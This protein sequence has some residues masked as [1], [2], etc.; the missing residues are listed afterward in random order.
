[1]FS[2]RIKM[3]ITGFFLLLTAFLSVMGYLFEILEKLISTDNTAI[4]TIIK[5]CTT[6]KDTF[7]THPFAFTLF[8]IGLAV[9][10]DLYYAFKYSNSQNDLSVRVGRYIKNLLA[11]LNI[12]CCIDLL[13]TEGLSQKFTWVQ[14]NK[15][16]AVLSV[17]GIIVF[18]IIVELLKKFSL[19]QSSKTNIHHA[20]RQREETAKARLR[21]ESEKYRQKSTAKSEKDAENPSEDKTLDVDLEIENLLNINTLNSENE[22]L[23]HPLSY[24]YENYKLFFAR[25]RLIK[26]TVKLKQ[27]TAQ[28][29]K[30]LDDIQKNSE[31]SVA[32]SGAF[33]VSTV[34]IIVIS[35][36][37]ITI[38][39]IQASGQDVLPNAAKFV[40][41]GLGILNTLLS[42]LTQKFGETQSVVISFLLGLGVII[43]FFFTFIFLV[44]TLTFMW[45]TWNYLRK[46]IRKNNKS[47]EMF[48]E[49]LQIFFSGTVT[50]V[51]KLLIFIP[52]F[53]E[54]IEETVL[55]MDYDRIKQ[56][57]DQRK[58]D[59]T[60]T[61]KD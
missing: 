11:G 10:D 27:I 18:V 30:D 41:E 31:G 38:I 44:Y 22:L 5:V 60:D 20:I 29:K 6:L 58:K 40:D 19:A 37:V 32:S 21:D 16:E 61:N 15:K 17:V 1:M 47:V 56:N 39:Y 59:D 43:L 57:I 2:R 25:K 24:M 51:T 42:T 36:I 26:R 28:A 53:L 45:E 49:D 9:L 35:L 8:F 55:D 7:A 12:I 4:L 46:N 50:S 14:Q 3:T 52:D 48:F 13:D 33:V 23:K 54:T 34:L